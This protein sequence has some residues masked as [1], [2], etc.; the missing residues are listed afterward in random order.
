MAQHPLSQAA[1]LV[2]V[3]R[4]TIYKLASSGRLSVTVDHQGRKV[5]ETVELLRVFGRLKAPLGGDT[6]GDTPG[7]RKRQQATTGDTA[8][9]RVE[10]VALL[11]ENGTLKIEL[12]ETRRRLAESMERER[13]AQ[14]RERR[15]R[16]R[17]DELLEIVRNQAR[18]LTYQPSEPPAPSA[19]PAPAPVPPPAPAPSAPSKPSS[20]FIDDA[21]SILRRNAERRAAEQA[22]ARAARRQ[23][24]H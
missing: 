20:G 14:E 23:R 18:Q 15:E 24:R 7:D 3:T 8:G 2:G 22:A 1:K 10:V 11:T 21:V 13:Q 16:E 9:D 19:A 17:V 6:T 5:V 4:Q 12:D